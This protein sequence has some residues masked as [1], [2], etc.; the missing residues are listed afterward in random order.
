MSAGQKGQQQR[1][2]SM[3]RRCTR[4][5]LPESYPEIRFDEYGVCNV[6]RA[7]KAP[8]V[9]GPEA[10]RQLVGTRRG[11]K[12]DCIVT[13]SG[14]RDSTYVLYYTTKVLG[15]RTLAGHYDNGFRHPLARENAEEVCRRAGAE[16]LQ[17]RS[18]DNL[19]ERI[20][21]AA[22]RSS[23]PFGPGACLHF[24]CYHCYSGGLCFLYTIAQ[25]L[26]IPFIFWGDSFVERLSF[27]P[28]RKK[29]RGYKGPLRH[30]L[31]SRGLSFLR[32]LR[33]IGAQRNE[34]LPPGNSRFNLKYPRLHSK[35][36]T[37]IHLYEY[38][39]WDRNTIKQVIT[40]ELGWRKPPEKLSSWRYDCSL[41][42]LVNYCHKKAMGFNHGIDGLSN[43][44]RAGK[45]TREEAMDLINR[46]Y[47][48]GEWTEELENLVRSKLE[49]PE[50]DIA[51]MKAW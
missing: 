27:F 17:F 51:T 16:L 25:E 50:S 44:V 14:G 15:L 47:D 48:S 5:V 3:E 20:A 4:C 1:G 22:I 38:V 12:Y 29:A 34:A 30:L 35:D 10:L 45:M 37:E 49:L 40:E 43:M 13:L 23:I 31:S 7:Y 6:C 2:V 11:E 28:I 8:P 9:K 24:C 19:N 42:T 41:H 26:K 39:E 21:A 32:M 36:I 33:L 18:R 46:G